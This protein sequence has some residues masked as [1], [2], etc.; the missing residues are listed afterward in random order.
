MVYSG[1]W[2]LLSFGACACAHGLTLLL[3]IQLFIAPIMFPGPKFHALLLHWQFYLHIISCNDWF[4]QR[5]LLVLRVLFL[6][7]ISPLPISGAVFRTYCSADSWI[8]ES[9]SINF[10]FFFNLKKKERKKFKVLLVHY[11][12]V[13]WL[14]LW[15]CSI[16]SSSSRWQWHLS[17]MRADF[18]QTIRVLIRYL[19]CG[20]SWLSKPRIGHIYLQM[21]REIF[22]FVQII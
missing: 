14:D 13:E 20:T 15:V 6:S 19:C 18:M 11:G 5:F 22:I 10:R 12:L 4:N 16:C 9:L 1:S 21:V 3:L 2:A 8:I 17:W 7:E